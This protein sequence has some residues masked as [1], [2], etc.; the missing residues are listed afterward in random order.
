[1]RL[2]KIK[3][4]GF[5][6]F[7]EPTIVHFE[8]RLTGI[9]GPNGCGKS[10]IIDAVRWVMGESSAKQLRGESIT[11]VIFN[12]STYRKPIGQASIELVFDN[13]S[14]RL[15]GE[16]AS[17]NQIAIKRQVS[18][19]GISLYYLNGTKCRRRDITD[20]FLGTGL[21]PRSYS[22]IEQG[23]ISEIIEAK[24][25]ELRIFLEEVAGISKY[26]ERRR[27]TENRMSHTLENLN[28]I[29][30][31]LA[32]LSQQ[33]EHLKK[34]AKAAERYKVL[35]EEERTIKAQLLALKW[36]GLAQEADTFHAA[37]H[38]QAVTL[39]S[40]KADLQNIDTHSE[41]QT[42]QKAELSQKLN[43][44][45]ERFYELGND[46][47]RLEQ[48]IAYQKERRQQLEFDLQQTE[49]TLKNM[50]IHLNDD[51]TQWFS[52]EKEASHLEPAI[53]Q[54]K[55]D[56]VSAQSD[57]SQA[58]KTMQHWQA[59]WDEFNRISAE[60][61]QKAT[62]EQTR[63]HHYE[64]QEIQA[65]QKLEKLQQELQHLGDIDPQVKEKQE[66]HVQI[67]RIQQEVNGHLSQI[68][69]GREA[70]ARYQQERQQ[71]EEGLHRLQ[72]ELRSKK[73]RHV[74]LEALQQVALGKSDG[75]ALQ[76]LKQHHFNQ[77]SRLAELLDVEKGWEKAVETVLS[78]QLS[79][80]QINSLNDIL[81]AF[82]S[83][84]PDIS[85][86]FFETTSWEM[87][88]LSGTIDSSRLLVHK[89]RSSLPLESGLSRVYCADSFQEAVQLRGL[90][91]DQASVITREGV[92]MG[93]NWLRVERQQD[94]KSGIIHREQELRELKAEI[95]E[96]THR[97]QIDENQI[98]EKRQQINQLE[99]EQT[100]HQ[101]AFHQQQKQ[102]AE[103]QVHAHAL[104]SKI[105]QMTQ[106]QSYIHSE[107]SD[108]QSHIQR[109]QA[110][111][112][113]SRERW[114]QAL[115]EIDR[116]KITHDQL[117]QEKERYQCQVNEFRQKVTH[118]QTALHALELQQESNKTQLLSL[119]QAL[120]RSNDQA[121]TLTT[122]KNQLIDSLSQ[123]ESPVVALKTQLE[124]TL[125]QR[126]IV[127]KELTSVKQA[128][129]QLN[130]DLLMLNQRRHE[131]EETIQAS[132]NQLEDQRLQVR[133]IQVRQK[134]LEE[135][136]VEMHAKLDDL[137]PALPDGADEQTWQMEVEKITLRISRLG[138]I[139]L[140]AIEEFEQ[141]QQRKNY[142]EAQHHDLQEALTILQN[143]IR[144]I[145]Q[146]TRSK[147]K[148]TFDTVNQNFQALFPKVFGG[149]SAYLELAQDDLLTT[150]ITVFAKPPGKRVSSIHLLSGG[151]KA[152]TAAA[153]L[154][155]MFQLNPSP[156]CML[157]EVDAPLDDANVLR[158]CE[159]VKEMSESVQF[160]FISHNKVAIEIAQQLMG[161]TMQ[162]P[163]VS[164]VVAVDIDQAMAMVDG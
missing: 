63:I 140:A 51:Q 5:K 95:A 89:I 64:M 113:C 127:E 11:D 19:D 74:A 53:E 146:E 71:M 60:A 93:K 136:L 135:Q 157:D 101:E 23:M 55:T 37:L 9:V 68:E 26:K 100:S 70:M 27:E 124:E 58:E 115:A 112:Q 57:F 38:R 77:H 111:L 25:E 99:I 2:E 148:E 88:P 145:D 137:L 90:L 24:P 83:V 17:Y 72:E 30:D 67:E 104:Q 163:G 122:K 105:Q 144:K 39:E 6:S 44:V 29:N 152:L 54:A 31:I 48:E 1:M 129:D 36:R 73:G 65:N 108:L 141:Q 28:R 128:I 143:A 149:G 119:Q 110:E 121:R 120:D 151:E 4:V 7:V 164:R 162:E 155:A 98:H 102:L 97:S 126:S 33:L 130:H 49:D 118:L 94:A 50:A 114:S 116:Y 133:E 139:N 106:R 10:N 107:M 52:L 15:G 96:L 47:S 79:A 109:D 160:I 103:L 91:P 12:G 13:S 66:L 69:N 14:G 8:K 75:D 41:K 18:R 82:E 80:I 158:F 154:F 156:F 153:L 20:I 43:H 61:T 138:P 16:Y 142:L 147:F 159:L 81:Q 40:L 3:L 35:R 123:V 34:Q 76:W 132:R 92:W 62:V 56:F 59:Q 84:V 21:G 86:G 150:G 78:S 131:L 87:L 42:Q 117:L 161:I 134:T 22:I 46:I 125:Q 45:Q 32:E 85:I